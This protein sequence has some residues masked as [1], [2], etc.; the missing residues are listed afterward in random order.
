MVNE[1]F[2]LGRKSSNSEFA[3]IP[4]QDELPNFGRRR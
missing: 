1:V 2:L 3:G 4:S